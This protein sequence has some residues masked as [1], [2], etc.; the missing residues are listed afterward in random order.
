M[1]K[2]AG[3]LLMFAGAVSV[4]LALLLFVHNQWE[5]KQ[6][7][8]RAAQVVAQLE[9]QIAEQQEPSA[10][11]EPE[12]TE[13]SSAEPEQQ[14]QALTVD[15]KTYIGYLSIPAIDLTLPVQ[16]EWSYQ[17]LK[18]APGRYSGSAETQDL[19]IAGHN[20]ARHFTPIKWLTVGTEVD[21]VDTGNRVWRYQVSAVETLQPEQVD[22]MIT[23]STSWDLTLF[24][25]T[26]GGGARYTVRCTAVI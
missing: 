11:A 18:T 24:A 14:P 7:E 2:E 9:E 21:F 10:A 26:A 1:R 5:A 12:P 8:E 20:Y 4:L 13:E 15:G 16:A 25:C 3:N 19:V 22:E 17:G 6:A 23:P